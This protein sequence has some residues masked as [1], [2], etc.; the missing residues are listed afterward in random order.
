[1]IVVTGANGQVGSAVCAL[2]GDDAV[3]ITRSDLD[4]SNIRSI[5]SVLERYQ[6]S[7]IINCAA[8]TAVDEAE[9]DRSAARTVNAD[10]VG[11]MAGVARELGARF[12]TF[13]TDYVFDGEKADS[14]A[15]SDATGP[16]NV[17]GE[18]KLTGE[19]MALEANP[20]SLIIRTSWVLSGTH[21][22]FVTT[23]IDLIRRGPV[24]VVDDQRGRPTMAE[25]LAAGTIAALRAG[26]T[27]LLHMTNAEEMTWFDLAGEIADMA[28]LDPDNVDPC[29]TEE[30]P[31]PARRPR[32]GCLRSER[33]AELELS[34]LP[35]FRPALERAVRQI[36]D[37]GA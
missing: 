36:V 16:L 15:E 32:N 23:M 13:S 26:A 33:L 7:A 31:R 17:Y 3:G 22:N 9:T 5:R 6:P 20:E 34:E 8:Y 1:V 21:P 30:F 12:V 27:G 25:D 28:D 35:S 2:L 11:E 14:Y 18:S 24:K 10:A 19:G 37:D 4:L 29:S